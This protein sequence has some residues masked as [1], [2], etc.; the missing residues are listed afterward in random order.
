M[1]L[2]DE[3]QGKLLVNDEHTKKMEWESRT[4]IYFEKRQTH[5]VNVTV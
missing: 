2:N 4:T 3:Q 1:I 5:H